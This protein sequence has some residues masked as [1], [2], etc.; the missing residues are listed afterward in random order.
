MK[1][2]KKRIVDAPTPTTQTPQNQTDQSNNSMDEKLNMN[3]TQNQVSN[4]QSHELQSSAN[5][6][7]TPDDALRY[8]ECPKDK[9]R[10]K[11]ISFSHKIAGGSYLAWSFWSAGKFDKY[12]NEN[13]W[14]QLHYDQISSGTLFYLAN[15]ARRSLGETPQTSSN[16]ISCEWLNNYYNHAG[17]LDDECL[18]YF[19]MRGIFQ[20]TLKMVPSVKTLIWNNKKYIIYPV[21]P[22][23]HPNQHISIKYLPICNSRKTGPAMSPKGSLREYNGIFTYLGRKGDKKDQTIIHIAEGL[24]TALS[25][26]QTIP[27]GRFYTANDANNLA[28]FSPNKCRELHIWADNDKSE[29]GQKSAIKLAT[30]CLSSIRVFIHLPKDKS[31]D[32]NDILQSEGGQQLILQSLNTCTPFKDKRSLQSKIN[33]SLGGRPMINY[34]DLAKGFLKKNKLHGSQTIRY[35][36]NAWYHFNGICYRELNSLKGHVMAFLQVN[37]QS[38]KNGIN[39][40]RAEQ[41]TVKSRLPSTSLMTRD[42]VIGN[43]QSMK[44]CGLSSDMNEPFWID[45]HEEYPKFSVMSFI[46]AVSFSPSK[47]KQLKHLSF[48]ERLK[49]STT[50]TTSR[51]FNTYAVDWP[52]LPPDKTNEPKW[53]NYYLESTQEHESDRLLIKQLLSLAV[54]NDLSFNV[55]M[56]IQGMKGTGKSVIIDLLRALIGNQNICSVPPQNFGQDG[57]DIGLSN[58]CLN[59]VEELSYKPLP[60][61]AIAK[62]KLA[63]EGKIC[64]F[65]KMKKNSFDAKIKAFNIWVGNQLPKMRDDSGACEDRL[66]LIKFKKIFRGSSDEKFNLVDLLMSELSS[67]FIDLLRVYADVCELAPA[68]IGKHTSHEELLQKQREETNPAQKFINEN[69]QQGSGY[70]ELQAMYEHYRTWCQVNGHYPESKPSFSRAIHFAF[71]IPAQRKRIDNTRLKVFEGIKKISE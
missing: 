4:K 23:S 15:E 37:Y 1:E 62:F 45:K 21:Q 58:K 60:N 14:T 39:A 24:E 6:N 49:K 70:V 8:I 42:N 11:E 28:K 38:A 64:G 5:F 3:S 54:M 31:T 19:E 7:L 65:R 13:F 10:W 32:W 40:E 53:F 46:N 66:R 51:L 71:G 61:D 30:R 9:M 12:L 44:L 22:N 25:L 27:R 50:R 41:T 47:F 17:I 20:N 63:T 33:G 2:K 52:L 16:N 69:Y 48:E 56:V 67:I 18:R 55:A 43:L 34:L 68:R 59:L 36:Q 29:T 35:Y 26:F 57:K